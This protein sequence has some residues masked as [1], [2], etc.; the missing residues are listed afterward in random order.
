MEVM[1]E[2]G[3]G[4]GDYQQLIQSEYSLQEDSDSVPGN[5]RPTNQQHNND[6]HPDVEDDVARSKEEHHQDAVDSINVGSGTHDLDSH[7]E[8][9]EIPVSVGNDPI[10]REPEVT[11]VHAYQRLEED[12]S[13]VEVCTTADDDLI[14]DEEE[15][16]QDVNEAVHE[17]PLS[18]QNDETNGKPYYS[19]KLAKFSSANVVQ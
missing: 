12:E 15:N 4:L 7:K 17:N 2:Q 19:S 9:L 5:D 14:D 13:V 11:L 10:P 6:T 3:K 16:S 8:R 1:L 18:D